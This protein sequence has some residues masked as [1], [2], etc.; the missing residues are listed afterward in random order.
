[1][2]PKI[3]RDLDSAKMHFWS[4]FGNP[5]FN[6]L[7]SMAWTTQNGVNFDFSVQFDHVSQG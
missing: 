5:N 1:M 6:W 7:G 3:N 4:K 2:K